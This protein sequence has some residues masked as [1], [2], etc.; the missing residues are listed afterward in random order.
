MDTDPLADP[1]HTPTRQSLTPDQITEQIT[2]TLVSGGFTALTA[3]RRLIGEGWQDFYWLGGW[4][5]VQDWMLG[6]HHDRARRET[7]ALRD[8]T[9]VDARHWGAESEAWLA[10]SL[11]IGDFIHDEVT[12]NG[13]TV[14]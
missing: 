11:I 2:S 14:R 10:A 4:P 3:S 9:R 5:K 6:E 13:V 12:V 1:P 8:G 7:A